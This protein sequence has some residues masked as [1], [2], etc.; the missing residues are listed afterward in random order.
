MP[1]TETSPPKCPH[2]GWVMGLMLTIERLGDL[3][4]MHVF[5]CSSMSH[6][7][8]IKLKRAP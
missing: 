6:G 1:R 2:R 5:Y 3:P 8:T 4:Q 7:K